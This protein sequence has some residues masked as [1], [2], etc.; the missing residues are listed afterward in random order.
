MN[1][2]ANILLARE[3]VCRAGENIS[4]EYFAANSCRNIK[5]TVENMHNLNIQ[6]LEKKKKQQLFKELH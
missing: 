2:Q 6:Y 4:Q 3:T 5:Y 1:F